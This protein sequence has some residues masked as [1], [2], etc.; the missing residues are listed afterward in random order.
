MAKQV[1]KLGIMG[2]HIFITM[3]IAFG[4]VFSLEAQDWQLVWADEFDG[5]ALDTEKWSFQTGTGSEY[6]LTDWGNNEEQYYREENVSVSDGM[7]HVTAKRESYGGKGYTSGRIRT[8]GKGDWTYGRIEFRAKLAR[9]QGMWSAVWMMP[10]DEVYGGWA[11]SGEIDIMENVGFE[12][13]S[14]HGTLHFGG[15]WP[16]NQS[17]GSAYETTGSPFHQEFYNYALEWEEGEMRW[18]V[19]DVLY[20]TLGEGDWNTSGHAFPAPFDQDF[21]LLVNLAVGG[22]WPGSPDATTDFPQELVLDYIRVYQDASTGLQGERLSPAQVR[23]Y[24]NPA[25]DQAA[26]SFV[27]EKD[28]PVQLDLLDASGRLLKTLRQEVFAKGRHHLLID[29]ADLAAGYYACR[30]KSPSVIIRRSLLIL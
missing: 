26:V 14:V 30:L 15:A 3:L 22:Y 7:L 1:K 13:L 23:L 24:P 11:A 8:K 20:Q 19:N 25:T 4:A 27:L 10:S 6:G 17:K 29:T 9:G 16:N 5:E 12:P 28:Q 2:K 18:Y 21:H